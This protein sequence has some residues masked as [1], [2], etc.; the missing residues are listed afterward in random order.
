MGILSATATLFIYITDTNSACTYHHRSFK[1]TNMI[2]NLKFIATHTRKVTIT[3]TKI[4]KRLKTS[5]TIQIIANTCYIT[6][7]YCIGKVLPLVA[8]RFMNWS[9]I[10]SRFL[11]LD[12]V[13]W[14]FSRATWFNR[15]CPIEDCRLENEHSELHDVTGT[16]FKSLVTSGNMVF[17]YS[18]LSPFRKSTTSWKE[19]K[20]TPGCFA[21]SWHI[22]RCRVNLI[23]SKSYLW[24]CIM[25]L[26]WPLPVTKSSTSCMY[27]NAEGLNRQSRHADVVSRIYIN[28]VLLQ[29][30]FFW[31]L[32]AVRWRTSV[33]ELTGNF[34]W[35][36]KFW[37]FQ[38]KDAGCSSGTFPKFFESFTKT[39][40]VSSEC[41]SRSVYVTDTFGEPCS[42]F[43]CERKKN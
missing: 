11:F 39:F 4:L 33:S 40:I 16:R 34:S 25:F 12:K 2:V 38:L 21:T 13:L 26:Q 10:A 20:D 17:K 41:P 37:A 23:S 43:L 36:E 5:S 42:Q 1:E 29:E 35:L 8:V 14:W 6:A 28:E 19:A 9:A 3:A 30:Q 22:S 7:I 32:K 18:P 24:N 27:L 15:A 31:C